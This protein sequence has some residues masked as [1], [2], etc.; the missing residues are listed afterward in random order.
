MRLAWRNLSHDRMRFVVTIIGI[1]FATFLMVFQGSLFTGFVR[2]SS[3]VIEAAD[4]GLWIV[5]RGVSC[6]GYCRFG[7]ESAFLAERDER[8]RKVT[9]NDCARSS[10]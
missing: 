7:A 9:R 1:A 2:A 4:A 3:K 6:T 5:P 8:R 10:A